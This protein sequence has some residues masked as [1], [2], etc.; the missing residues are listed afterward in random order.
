[1]P[2]PPLPP[3]PSSEDLPELPDFIKVSLY[4]VLQ[5]ALTNVQKHTQASNID[6]T[7]GLEKGAVNLYIHDN[8]RGFQQEPAVAMSH[9]IGLKG[10]FNRVEALGG[11][12]KII[13]NNTKGTALVVKIPWREMP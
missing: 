4:R 11:S 6:I 5:E 7:L 3:L 13:T 10:I 9:G 1:M 2:L 8:G 12:I